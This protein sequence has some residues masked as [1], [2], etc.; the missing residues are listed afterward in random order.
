MLYHAVWL[1]MLAGLTVASHA[2]V[3]APASRRFL[4]TSTKVSSSPSTLV[5][6]KTD[7]LVDLTDENCKE[8]ISGTCL[9]K[10]EARWC[11]PCRLISP[12]VERI[13]EEW[14]ERNLVVAKFDVDALNPDVKIELLLQKVTPTSLPSL[15]LFQKGKAIA[16]RNGV[17]TDEE[18]KAFL[19][20]HLTTDAT[21]SDATSSLA[22]QRQEKKVSGFIHM[23]NTM[24]EYMLGGVF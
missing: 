16:V 17:V 19:V 14:H 1:V 4:S 15:I 7:Y 21:S 3:I 11:G 2:F 9:I 18:L 22:D 5:Q 20:E 24:D 13:A 12:V 23:V 6:E 8:L 10:A